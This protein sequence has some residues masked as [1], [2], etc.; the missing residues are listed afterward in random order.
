MLEEEIFLNLKDNN[1]ELINFFYYININI[2]FILYFVF[3]SNIYYYSLI[4]IIL[5]LNIYIA[6]LNLNNIYI[7]NKL[8]L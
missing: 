4:I 7:Y 2:E 5:I 8:F 1:W 6:F 3:S